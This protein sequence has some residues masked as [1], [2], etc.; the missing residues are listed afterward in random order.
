MVETLCTHVLNGKMR[1][2][3]TIAG[4]GEREYLRMKEGINYD[5]L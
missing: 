4:I 5:T 1:S 2:V 3:E